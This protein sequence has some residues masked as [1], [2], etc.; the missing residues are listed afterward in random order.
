MKAYVTIV[1]GCN[2]YCTYCVVP[3]TRGH[4]RMRAKAE[5]LEEVRAV[6]QSGR[7]E[8]QLLGQ[9]VNH[10]QAPDEPGC[11]FPACSRPSARSPVCSEFGSPARTHGTARPG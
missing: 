11:D 4:E 5:I 6:V 2:D 7:K 8:I 3:Y 9:I 10:Y 1:E